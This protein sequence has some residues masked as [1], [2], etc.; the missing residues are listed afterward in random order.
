MNKE[1]QMMPEEFEGVTDTFEASKERLENIEV[2]IRHWFPMFE[3]MDTDKFR[4]ALVKMD[5][6][7]W[8]NHCDLMQDW[9]AAYSWYLLWENQTDTEIEVEKRFVIRDKSTGRSFNEGHGWD[10][11]LPLMRFV[12]E[13]DAWAF[14]QDC[15]DFY[16]RKSH[17]ELMK[18]FEVINEVSG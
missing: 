16:G 11:S 2:K 15:F 8:L 1:T 7:D 9:R 10:D 4:A 13:E 6:M 12:A 18:A 17:E 5:Q 3:T 14:A